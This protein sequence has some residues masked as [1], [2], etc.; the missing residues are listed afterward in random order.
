MRDFLNILKE[1]PAVNSIKFYQRKLNFFQNE[2]SFGLFKAS[3][4]NNI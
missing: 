4:K 1:K 3:S 2:V